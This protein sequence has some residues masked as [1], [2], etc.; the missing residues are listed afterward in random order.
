MSLVPKSQPAHPVRVIP[1]LPILVVSVIH[2]GAIA[3]SLQEL[4]VWTK[5][6]L[7]PALALGL[8]WAAPHRRSPAILL[9][10]VALFFSWAGDVTIHWFVIGLGC[11]LLAHAAY[12]VLFVGQLAVRRVQWW[13]ITYVAWLVV[14]LVMLL[15]AAG[16]LAI[17]VTI[18]GI[19]LCAMGVFAS[20]CNGWVALGGALF[21]ASDSILAIDRFLPQDGIPFSFLIMITYIGAQT[22]IVW[23]IV[24]HERARLVALAP[25]L[26]DPVRNSA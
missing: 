17:P 8:V 25:A 23:G 5:P 1:F 12:L 2:L 22:L 10:L 6:L 3:F 21:I 20:R 13:S 19:T 15:P 4:V 7:M 9:G 14:L 18:Y 16:P 11:F 24:Q 26:A